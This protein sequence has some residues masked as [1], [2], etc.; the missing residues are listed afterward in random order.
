MARDQLRVSEVGSLRAFLENA[1]QVGT[2]VVHTGDG[3]TITLLGVTLDD[4][5]RQNFDFS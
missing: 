1:E 2:D 5:S 4:L 3:G